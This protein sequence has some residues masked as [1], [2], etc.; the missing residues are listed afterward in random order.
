MTFST[1]GDFAASL[2]DHGG[3]STL[4]QAKLPHAA[5]KVAAA[6]PLEMVAVVPLD[7]DVV[8]VLAGSWGPQ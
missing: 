2:D 7:F 4:K 3:V 5:W 6:A 1:L 8:M